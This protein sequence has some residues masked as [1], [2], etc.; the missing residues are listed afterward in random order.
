MSHPKHVQTL[1]S[2]VASNRSQSESEK[3][4]IE[5][6][7][8]INREEMDEDQRKPK[9]SQTNPENL[10]VRSRYEKEAMF[11]Y[12]CQNLRR[13][14]P[15]HRQKGVQILEPQH[16]KDIKTVK[17]MRMVLRRSYEGY[18]QQHTAPFLD[19]KKSLDAH[20]LTILVSIT[21]LVLQGSGKKKVFVGLPV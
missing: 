7:Q 10:V 21:F 20:N 19:G 1:E 4:D 16:C 8:C 15:L 11:C 12:F 14:T 9:R 6:E 17:N 5:E 13:Q 3:N 18:V 2:F